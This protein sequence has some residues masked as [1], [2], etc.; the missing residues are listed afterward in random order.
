M[1]GHGRDERKPTDDATA[2]LSRPFAFRISEMAESFPARA[3]QASQ[4]ALQEFAASGASG[5]TGPRSS[6]AAVSSVFRA[7]R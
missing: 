4:G 5:Q 7:R 1:P 2:S 6:A 3:D